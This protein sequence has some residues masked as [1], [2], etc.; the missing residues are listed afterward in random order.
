MDKIIPPRLIE[1]EEKAKDLYIQE[2]DWNG[3][4][5]MLSKEEQIEYWKLFEETFGEKV[6]K[7]TK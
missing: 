3:V 2:S 7:E 5:N 4:V 6:M 1:L